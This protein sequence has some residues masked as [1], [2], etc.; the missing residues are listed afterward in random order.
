VG[1]DVQ[2]KSEPKPEV[3][4]EAEAEGA[5]ADQVPPELRLGNTGYLCPLLQHV[6]SPNA[7]L[8]A[9]G[10][11]IEGEP[12][13]SH[14]T[15]PPFGP[16]LL[17][18]QTH[19]DPTALRLEIET[20]LPN[21]HIKRDMWADE[22]VGKMAAVTPAAVGKVVELFM[23]A[24]VTGAAEK[25]TQTGSTKA[26]AAHLAQVI[27]G[28]EQYDFLDDI[29]GRVEKRKEK[30]EERGKKGKGRSKAP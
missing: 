18:Q 7:S 11:Q 4:P 15:N 5:V 26:T 28:D 21:A 29:V 24:L 23:I 3:K 8:F 30:E 10:P 25:A 6:I 17:S 20:K 1:L 27:K 22:D 9:H 16:P 12:S 19:N 2:E 14:T 13:S